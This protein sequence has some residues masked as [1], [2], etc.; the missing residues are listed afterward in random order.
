MYE[1]KFLLREVFVQILDIVV[2]IS[3]GFFPC[4]VH[5]FRDTRDVNYDEMIYVL[6]D[7]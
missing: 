4:Q 7:M 2:A 1:I 5:R 6:C 3:F